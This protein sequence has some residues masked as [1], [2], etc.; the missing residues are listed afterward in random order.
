M[1]IYT[2]EEQNKTKKEQTTATC[3][4]LLCKKKNTWKMKTL[5]AKCK[6]WLQ[7]PQLLSRRVSKHTEGCACDHHGQHVSKMLD[8]LC[9]CP[10]R[11]LISPL[12]S[13]PERLNV[14]H[15]HFI[16]VF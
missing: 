4:I 3:F 10:T 6:H 16:A 1:M 14:A 13:I 2:R 12:M 5:K 9:F 7:H 15:S 8:E 11:W